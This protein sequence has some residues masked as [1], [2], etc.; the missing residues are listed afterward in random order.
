MTVDRTRLLHEPQFECLVQFMNDPAEILRTADQPQ[1][2]FSSTYGGFPRFIWF[3]LIPLMLL[4]SAVLFVN[5][6][7]FPDGVLFD[8][9]PVSPSIAAYVICP[10]I[11]ILCALFAALEVYR[12]RNPQFVLV[13]TWG[14]RL[15][16]GRFTSEN[17]AIA[18]DDLNAS[19]KAERFKGFSV[20]EIFC[21]D[22]RNGASARVTSALFRSFDD[23]ATFARIMGEQIGRDWSIKGFLPGTV[24]GRKPARR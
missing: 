23:F 7:W 13:S 6:V 2:L 15:P 20:Y 1:I 10:L 19:L 21:E 3:A 12:L 17:I 24:R 11:W 16:K 14:V 9:A 18:W 22:M 4:A 8:T 5:A